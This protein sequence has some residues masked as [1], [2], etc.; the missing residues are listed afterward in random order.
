MSQLHQADSLVLQATNNSR[1][2]RRRR[3]IEA[4]LILDCSTVAPPAVVPVV[5]PLMQLDGWVSPCL[6]GVRYRESLVRHV[7]VARVQYSTVLVMR[8][9]ERYIH[10]ESYS[11]LV[12]YLIPLHCCSHDRWPM[13]CQHVW[14]YFLHSVR[15]LWYCG[16]HSIPSLSMS[17]SLLL[18][19]PIYLTW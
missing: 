5:S 7:I 9:L 4:S 8:K 19:I 2:S 1:Q 10:A 3:S 11:Q 17:P 16:F 15:V 12:T 18:L 6:W 13:C 14:Q